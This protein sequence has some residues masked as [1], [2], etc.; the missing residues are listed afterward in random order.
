MLGCGSPFALRRA[1]LK[2][3]RRISEDALIRMRRQ[4]AERRRCRRC[5]RRY[6]SSWGTEILIG[7]QAWHATKLFEL[8]QR[9][10]RSAA[11]RVA[12]VLTDHSDEISFSRR[13]Y[14]P[15]SPWKIS[16][17][18]SISSASDRA[19]LSCALSAALA[20]G[21]LSNC[22]SSSS[23]PNWEGGDHVEIFHGTQQL[24]CRSFFYD[25]HFLFPFLRRWRCRPCDRRRR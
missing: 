9:S 23:S 4:R 15:I 11:S 16:R 20:S 8:L 25:A 22:Q 10:K 21:S 24:F 13:Q 12:G 14:S 5:A 6:L 3:V 7:L 18:N 2:M 17:T 19:L 1:R